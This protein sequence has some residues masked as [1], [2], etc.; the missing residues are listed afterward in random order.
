MGRVVERS[1]PNEAHLRRAVLAEDRDLTCRTPKDP[2]RAAVV[3]WRVNRVRR[4][5]E[6][7][8]AVSL[9]SRLTTNALP[10]WRWQFKQW[11]Q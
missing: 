7:L 6:H 10:V 11:Q 1:A 5:R 2:L 3:A 8:H 4:S 9:I